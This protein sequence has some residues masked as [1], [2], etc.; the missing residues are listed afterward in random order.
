MGGKEIVK[1]VINTLGVGRLRMEITLSSQE[2]L[3]LDVIHSRNS[4]GRLM[5]KKGK[6]R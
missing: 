2:S 4:P 3:E 5:K 6:V 1:Q